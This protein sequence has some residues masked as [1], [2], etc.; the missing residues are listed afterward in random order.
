MGKEIKSTH[1]YVVGDKCFEVWKKSRK[2]YDGYEY[3]YCI[4]KDIKHSLMGYYF[5]LSVLGGKVIKISVDNGRKDELYEFWDELQKK[6][7][8]SYNPQ[9]SARTLAVTASKAIPKVE[10]KAQEKTVEDSYRKGDVA[11]KIKCP[12]CWSMEFQVIGTK[13]KFSV[14]KAVVGNTVGGMVFGPVGA[15]VGAATGIQ[16]K[17]GKTKF[18]CNHCGNVWEQ[19]V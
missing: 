12:N 8:E 15:V 4:A 11:T 5:E 18:V 17:N 1:T 3:E 13:K 9:K 7:K 6:I 16:G 10:V 19:K 2:G 14:G